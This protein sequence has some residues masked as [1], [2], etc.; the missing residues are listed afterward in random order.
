[1]K[2]DKIPNSE[3]MVEG[4]EIPAKGTMSTRNQP[5]TA[6]PT[7]EPSTRAPKDSA[8]AR[9]KATRL[10]FMNH[11]VAPSAAAISKPVGFSTPSGCA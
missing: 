2:R 8:A 7:M 3:T 1:M 4:E 9:P 5:C 6:P 11:T 10:L